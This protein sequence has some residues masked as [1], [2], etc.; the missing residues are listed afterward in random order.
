M[1]VILGAG[2]TGLSVAYHLKKKNK[3]FII[4]EKENVPGGLC[5]NIKIDGYTFNYTGHF[6]HCKTS[7]VENLAKKLVPDIKKV[8]RNSY[9]YLNRKIIPYPIQSNKAYLSMAERVK[10]FLSYHLT[11]NRKN[12]KNLEEWFVYNFG[13]ELYNIFFLPYNEKLWKFSLKKISPDFLRSYVPKETSGQSDEVGEYNSEFLYPDKGIGV[14]VSSM[15]K[16]INILH[17]EVTK[18]ERKYVYCNGRKI[19]YEKLISTIPLPELLKM[20]YLNEDELRKKGK[21]LNWN[22]VLCIN[23]GLKETLSFEKTVNKLKKSN[24]NPSDFHWIYFPEKKFPFY[25]VGSLSNVSPR[26]VPDNHSSIWVEISYRGKKPGK[27]ITEDVINNLEKIGFLEKK[28]ID[29]I[30]RVYIPYAY[31]IYDMNW[32]RVTGEIRNSLKNQNIILAGRFGDWR[33]SYMEESIL[34]GKKVALELCR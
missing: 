16:D 15:A 25:R 9:V 2:I 33:Y 32:A 12:S 34:E 1:T 24:L 30:S 7:Y 17:G 10:S 31:P 11:K 23:I 22:S 4:I 19:K 8:R 13:R 29:H 18:I 26:L 6:L 21:Y 27:R 20:L 14:L 5:R 28:T 3:D